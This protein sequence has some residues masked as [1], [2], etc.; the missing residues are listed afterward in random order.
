[1]SERVD[2]NLCND[3]P[4]RKDVRECL[5]SN[6]SACLNSNAAMTNRDVS[7][8]ECGNG[9]L[10]RYSRKRLGKKIKETGTQ[11]KG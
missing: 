11:K 9:R 1:M 3:D 2:M 10:V 4:G 6:V 8:S 7:V 5:L